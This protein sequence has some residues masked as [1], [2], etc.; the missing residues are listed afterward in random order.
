[1]R[2]I[3]VGNSPPGPG[4]NSLR[5]LKAEFF[6]RMCIFRMDF[7]EFNICKKRVHSS[8]PSWIGITWQTL[9]L[10]ELIIN[11]EQAFMKRLLWLQVF[12][13]TLEPC[14]WH[15]SQCQFW[16]AIFE[17]KYI[18]WPSTRLSHLAQS[19]KCHSGKLYLASCR[20][21]GQKP[22]KNGYLKH[23]KNNETSKDWQLASTTWPIASLFF[24]SPKPLG[25][26]GSSLAERWKELKL[27]RQS[28]GVLVQAFERLVV[29]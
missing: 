7:G 24:S 20:F 16:D 17:N 12:R 29:F 19:A 11:T 2:W 28:L 25:F 21:S 10:Y 4:A 9:N 15:V 5:F 27:K 14:K 22:I 23:T 18:L 13:V 1:M 8:M 26:S 3:Q 6:Q